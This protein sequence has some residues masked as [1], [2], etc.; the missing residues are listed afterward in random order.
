MQGIAYGDLHDVELAR[1]TVNEV[2]TPEISERV[3][4]MKAETESAL[5]RRAVSGRASGD[6]LI[7]QA[8][9]TSYRMSILQDAV[10]ERLTEIVPVEEEAT[11]E[12]ES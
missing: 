5:A 10:I 3:E 11:Q 1:A 8:G 7:E 4:A 6:A 12:A 9:Y 2:P